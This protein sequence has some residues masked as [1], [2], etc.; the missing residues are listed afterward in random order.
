MIYIKIGSFK[1]SEG[2]QTHEVVST[3][4]QVGNLFFDEK[5]IKTVSLHFKAALQKMEML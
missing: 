1:N 4:R 3:S 5:Y 2:L